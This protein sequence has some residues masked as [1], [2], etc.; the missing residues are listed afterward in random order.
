MEIKE[1]VPIIIQVL[2]WFLI[3]VG[4]L[5][6]FKI[7][8]WGS[9]FSA[10]RGL[11]NGLIKFLSVVAGIGI[12]RFK[13]WAV[14]LYFGMYIVSSIV[15]YVFPPSEEIFDLYITPLPIFLLILVPTVIAGVVYGHWNRFK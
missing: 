6:L 3:I 10:T 2:G 11:W 4:T 14:Y 8:F 7:V 5:Y 15:L 1:K 12:L 13:K 9:D